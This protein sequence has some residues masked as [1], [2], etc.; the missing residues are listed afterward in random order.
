MTNEIKTITSHPKRFGKSKIMEEMLEKMLDM[1]LT[2][3]IAKPRG[4]F[5][6]RGFDT[7]KDITP[8]TDDNKKD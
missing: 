3:A 6:I 1:G 8:K 7:A 2:I 4:E 5:E